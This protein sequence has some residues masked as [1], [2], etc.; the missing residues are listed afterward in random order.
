MDAAGANH[1]LLCEQVVRMIDMVEGSNFMVSLWPSSSDIGAVIQ[2]G[3]AMRSQSKAAVRA[4]ML[5]GFVWRCV[6]MLTLWFFLSSAN[7][8]SVVTGQDSKNL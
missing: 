2:I 8:Y 6:C 5:S 4:V 7:I 3:F 1:I